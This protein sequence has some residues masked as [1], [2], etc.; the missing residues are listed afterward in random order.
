MRIQIRT[1]KSE[2]Y[3][4][5]IQD[6]ETVKDIKDKIEGELDLGAANMMNLIHHGT[7]LRNEQ[8]VYE[9]G[10]TENDF[11]V[12][13][14]KKARKRSDESSTEPQQLSEPRQ[15]PESE[16]RSVYRLD[17]ER[18]STPVVISSLGWNSH[19]SSATPDGVNSE[20]PPRVANDL[21]LGTELA[22][23]VSN[24][25]AMGFS[26]ADVRLAMNAAYNNPQRAAEYLLSGIPESVMMQH[27]GSRDER[28][29][30]TEGSDVPVGRRRDRDGQRAYR[31]LGVP[32]D[33]S[34]L[35]SEN[36]QAVS[37]MVQTLIR[38]R[39]DTFRRIAHPN[40]QL[41]LEALEVALCDP[42]TVR[43]MRETL[44]AAEADAPN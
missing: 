8:K 29:S 10:F 20:E 16:S 4:I 38:Y 23:V 32:E 39:P 33:L 26:P 28:S 25:V 31:A 42:N 37:E 44:D 1:L 35:L 41:N 22:E 43:V 13:M 14:L 7:I 17:S 9:I 24:F 11:V 15:A 36:P 27:Q 3:T 34:N 18:N 30:S 21:V 12:L 2:K 19:E 40:G 6:T 5:E